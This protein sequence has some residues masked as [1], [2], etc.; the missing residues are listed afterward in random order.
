MPI[1]LPC[2]F[3]HSAAPPST[4]TNSSQIDV[5]LVSSSGVDK[6]EDLPKRDSRDPTPAW[7][8]WNPWTV[9][10]QRIFLLALVAWFP[11]LPGPPFKR[12][13]VSG[14]RIS[15]DYG[16]SQTEAIE[17]LYKINP[18]VRTMELILSSCICWGIYSDPGSSVPVPHSEYISFFCIFWNT[19]F[20]ILSAFLSQH[21]PKQRMARFCAVSSSC[22]SGNGRYL[23][24]T[25]GRRHW[26]RKPYFIGL[27][28]RSDRVLVHGM[29]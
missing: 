23:R 1:P 4:V 6:Q 12:G 14:L 22:S 28:D 20:I 10:L 26:Y 18:W 25:Q 16:V 17:E 21:A 13:A 3:V 29:R 24:D 15:S 11:F 5:Q 2:A 27:Q 7:M 19:I 9:L 8:E